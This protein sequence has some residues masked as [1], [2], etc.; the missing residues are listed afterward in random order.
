MPTEKSP[1]SEPD[2]RSLDDLFAADPLSLTDTDVDR[3]AE[4]LRAKRAL[5]EKEDQE[6]KAQGRARRPTAYRDAPEKGQ[7]SL[8]DLKL[9]KPSQ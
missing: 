4:E 5:W 6:S 7:L 1:L 9:G 3:I 8:K 2:P